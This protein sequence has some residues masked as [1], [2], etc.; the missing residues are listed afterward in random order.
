MNTWMKSMAAAIALTGLAF[1]VQ[2]AQAGCG[3]PD[4]KGMKP[5]GWFDDGRAG[6]VKTQFESG[7]SLLRTGLFGPFNASG[8]TGLWQFEF[9]VTSASSKI[10][11]ASALPPIGAL[12][13][14]GF[15][16]WHDDGTEIMNSGRAPASGSFCLG[17]WKQTGVYTYELNHWALSWI[18][19][20][21]PG[22]T[23]SWS[24]TPDGTDGALAFAGPTNIQETVTLSREDAKSY[25]GQFTLTQYNPASDPHAPTFDTSG[26]VLLVIKG[27]ISATR[28]T[29]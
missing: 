28:V 18:P 6:F 8:I 29:P 13:D 11:P 24:Q 21:S 22:A 20:Y 12:A 19:G 3:V 15:V 4:A 16:Q 1:S 14:S 23:T 25:T 10:L 26:G 2:Q 5:T 27:T 7:G 9:T 17:V